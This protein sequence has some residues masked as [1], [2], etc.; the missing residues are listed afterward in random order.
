MPFVPVHGAV[1]VE[2]VH[3]LGESVCETAPLFLDRGAG[4]PA[5]PA[6]LGATVDE[7]WRTRVL[8]HLSVVLQYQRYVLRPQESAGDTPT[9]VDHIPPITGGAGGGC[10]PANVAVRVNY[11]LNPQ[12]FINKG[13]GFVPG[14][15][16]SAVSNNLIRPEFRAVIESAYND[17]I[18]LTMLVGWSWIVAHKIRHGAPLPTA[19][20]APVIGAMISSPWVAQ[21]RSR[22]HNDPLP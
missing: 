1:Q 5:D 14:I 12:L 17:L 3:L 6:V 4:G 13:C 22:L 9:I 8:P 10:C 19:A 16:H 11:V 18:A 15:P 20:R 21:R 2:L 7:W